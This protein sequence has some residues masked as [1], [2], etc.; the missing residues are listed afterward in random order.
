MSKRRKPPPTPFTARLVAV[1]LAAGLSQ[2][3]AAEKAGVP[4]R[5]LRDYEQ[6][7]RLPGAVPFL[8]LC[9]ATGADPWSFLPE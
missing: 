6:G 7:W 4:V 3:Q 9:R 5:T 2:A 1:R 8:R